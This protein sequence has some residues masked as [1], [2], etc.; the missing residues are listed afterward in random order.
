MILTVD[1]GNTNI[2][3]GAWDHD[4][5]AFV[6]RLQTNLLKTQDEYAINLLDIFRLNDCNAGQFD[7]AIISSVVP[8]L[9]SVFKRAVQAVLSARRVYVVSPGLK[10][11]LDIKIDNPATLGADMVCC[12]V[13][14]IEEYPLPCIIVSIG[15]ATAIC[16]IDKDGCFLGGSVSPGVS[17]ALD[18][19]ANRTAQL[20]HISLDSPGDLIGTNT[21]D[22]MKSGSIYGTACMLD[23]MTRRMKKELGG[24]ASI[25]ACGG[26]ASYITQHCEEKMAI[27]DDLVL[28]GLRLIYLKNTKL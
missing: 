23:G 19:L 2:K 8:P 11:G 24:G 22:S 1:I 5:L 28:K 12:A 21:I 18:A 14:A 17:I 7:G 20:P 16:A 9:S 26:L 6:S 3:V 25:I 13:A 27:D 15:T 4:R 10:T